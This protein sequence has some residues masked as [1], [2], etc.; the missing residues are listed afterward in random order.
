MLALAVAAIACQ[1]EETVVPKLELSGP[2]QELTI[3]ANGGAVNIE[4]TSNVEWSA[5]VK[6]ANWCT[7]SPVSGFS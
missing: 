7:V 4:F 5:A 3:P 6:S 1:K 2:A